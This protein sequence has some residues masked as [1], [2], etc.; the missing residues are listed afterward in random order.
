MKPTLTSSHASLELDSVPQHESASSD[1]RSRIRIAGFGKSAFVLM[2][3]GAFASSV[4]A[5]TVTYVAPK[6]ATNSSGSIQTSTSYLSNLGY[7]FMTG[8]S[9]TYDIDWINLGLSTNGNTSG[10]A[11]LK[12][13]IH[14]TNNATPYS[15]VAG[16]TAFATDTVNFTMPNTTATNFTLNLTSEKLPNITSYQLLPNTSYALF[17][18]NASGSLALQRTTGYTNG[19]TN[20]AY[21]VSNGFTMLDTFRNNTPNYANLAGSSYPTFAISFGATE[22]AQVPEA[23][24]MALLAVFVGGGLARRRRSRA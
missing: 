10:S 3:V 4:S 8:S 7:A 6:D 14:S 1:A 11:S 13:A 5:A 9:G 2:A 18:Y 22:Q 12:I 17:I 16:S 24:T 21:A 19:T 20:D 15:A 23:S